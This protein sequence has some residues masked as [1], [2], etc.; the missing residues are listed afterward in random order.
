MRIIFNGGEHSSHRAH[1]IAW[2]VEA[3]AVNFK[4]LAQRNKALPNVKDLFPDETIVMA[5]CP[6]VADVDLIA[7]YRKWCEVNAQRLQFSVEPDGPSLDER[8]KQRDDAPWV[9]VW[10]ADDGHRALDKLVSEYAV[11]SVPQQTFRSERPVT[12]RINRAA[13]A[14]LFVHGLGVG[15]QSLM[16]EVAFG[17]ISNGN[18]R[19][20]PA[21]GET[22]MWDGRRIIKIP[23]TRKSE[24]RKHVAILQRSGIDVDAVMADDLYALQQLAV[25]S[26]QQLEDAITRGRGGGAELPDT[27]SATSGA[28]PVKLPDTRVVTLSSSPART[29]DTTLLPVLQRVE[30]EDGPSKVQLREQ[31][32]RKCDSCV[33]ATR[34]CPAVS[35]GSTCAYEIPVRFRTKDELTACFATL[36]EMQAQRLFLA[37]FAEE[38]DGSIDRG[39]SEELDRW[40]RMIG[41]YDEFTNASETFKMNIE[42]RGKSGVLSRVF[43][44]G[45]GRAARALPAEI[46]ADPLIEDVIDV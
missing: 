30:S 27:G 33:L 13:L 8:L 31:S 37:R 45:L 1:L 16:G 25:W 29:R 26:W 11:I 32:V 2:G 10:T 28:I 38:L 6:L 44:D 15:R 18:W 40:T 46:P 42:A 12:P 20:A 4:T 21:N 17:S 22:V 24:R 9:P 41:S 36:I 5:Y 3:I 14:G 34:G 35:P 39:L 23:A 19:T 43:G 7:T